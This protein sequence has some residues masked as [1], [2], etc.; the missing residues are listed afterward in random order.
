V[1]WRSEREPQAPAW[2]RILLSLR[3]RL[4]FSFVIFFAIVLVGIGF[5]FRETLRQTLESHARDILNEEYVS[6]KGYLRI[7]HNTDVWYADKEDP[8]E[9]AFLQRLRRIILVTEADGHVLEA[10]DAYITLGVDSPE[11][12]KRIVASGKTD[13]TVRTNTRGVP[14]LIR[15]SSLIDDK[16]QYFLAIGR[17][18]ADDKAITR[19]FTLNY[20]ALLPLLLLAASVMGWFF[21]G[22]PLQPVIDVAATAQRIS[23]ENLALRIP[24]RGAGDELDHLIGTFNSMMDRLDA[25]FQQTRQFSANVSH[26]LRTPLTVIRGQLEVALFTAQT[27]DQYRDAIVNALQDVERLTH[28]VKTL[29][30]LSQAESGHLALQRLTLDLSELVRDIVEEFQIPADEAQVTL[31]AETPPGCFV[32]ADRVQ[33]ERLLTNLLS[34]AMKYTRA[35]GSVHVGVRHEGDWVELTVADNG[36]GI[37][38]D[39]LPRIFDRFFRVPDPEVRAERGLGL[40][41]S[42]VAWIVK[43]HDGLIDVESEAGRGTRF[44]VKL[45]AGHGG[46]ADGGEI[47]ATRTVALPPGPAARP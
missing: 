6:I 34:N 7:E 30:L 17:P 35:G 26:E 42:F 27:T 28:I 22:P 11:E 37:P 16:K 29:L 10:S 32:E 13:W 21:A 23:G 14:Y 31:T 18:I 36:I 20:L 9:A 4:A 38:A 47:A 3:F 25:S 33:M 8:E 24:R 40:G 12:V 39:H 2:K 44:V 45:P 1:K 46:A 15:R 19:A 41:L 43:A 5:V